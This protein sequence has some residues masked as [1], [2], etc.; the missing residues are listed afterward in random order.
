M[1][2]RI[3]RTVGR[4]HQPAEPGC[5]RYADSDVKMMRRCVE[6]STDGVAKL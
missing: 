6:A 5:K 3:A 1:N 4:G 2:V